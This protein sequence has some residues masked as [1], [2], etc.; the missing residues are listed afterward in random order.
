QST[1]SAPRAGTQTSSLGGNRTGDLRTP[2]APRAGTQTSS[3]GGNR[4]GDLRL[5]A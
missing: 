3:L 2:S 4:T 5:L 1:P